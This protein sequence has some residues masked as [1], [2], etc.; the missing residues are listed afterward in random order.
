MCFVG[1]VRGS[2][3][4]TARRGRMTYEKEKSVLAEKMTTEECRRKALGLLGVDELANMNPPDFRVE[5]KM[6]PA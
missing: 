4:L 1:V 3:I 5:G 6:L 2:V